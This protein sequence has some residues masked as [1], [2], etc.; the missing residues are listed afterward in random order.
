MVAFKDISGLELQSDCRLQLLNPGALLKWSRD[1]D[2]TDKRCCV[3]LHY[4]HHMIDLKK[5][6]KSKGMLNTL[7]IFPRRSSY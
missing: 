2:L 6:K 3:F 4:H 1:G 5:I 7:Q